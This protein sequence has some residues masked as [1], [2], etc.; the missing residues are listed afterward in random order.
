MRLF[1]FALNNK[2]AVMMF[3]VKRNPWSNQVR[4]GF[5]VSPGKLAVLGRWLDSN[6]SCGLSSKDA[7]E[8]SSSLYEASDILTIDFVSHGQTCTK[9]NLKTEG[10]KQVVER[11]L[12]IHSDTI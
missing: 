2:T 3:A 7:R 5:Q 6:E 4:I 11:R 10:E 12:H 9:G 8:H 1:G